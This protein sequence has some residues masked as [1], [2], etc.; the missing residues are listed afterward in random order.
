MVATDFSPEKPSP[1]K[2]TQPSPPYKSPSLDDIFNMD[3]S[4]LGLSI[5]QSRGTRHQNEQPSFSYPR[6]ILFTPTRDPTTSPTRKEDL[7]L[8]SDY[9]SVFKSRPKIAVSPTL[10]P[11]GGP[12]GMLPNLSL[13]SGMNGTPEVVVSEGYMTGFTV[14]HA[15]PLLVKK[16]DRKGKR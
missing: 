13:M 8:S 14:E 10:T 4:S 6:E 7:L 3:E 15:S 11:A 12:S 2:R 16:S 5:Y 9:N 1:A